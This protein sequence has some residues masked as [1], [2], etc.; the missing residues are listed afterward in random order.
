MLF[1]RSDFY[2]FNLIPSTLPIKKTIRSDY[3]LK[4][5][6]LYAAKQGVFNIVNGILYLNRSF[7]AYK[8]K[9]QINKN[10][11][12][13]GKMFLYQKKTTDYSVVFLTFN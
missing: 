13:V 1:N 8:M 10:D 9:I 12:R 11:Y 3:F 4:N 2:H 5:H 6:E 7:T